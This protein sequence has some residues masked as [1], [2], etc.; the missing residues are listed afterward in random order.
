MPAI[1]KASCIVTD[2]HSC[3]LTEINL[4]TTTRDQ[5]LQ[6]EFSS[7]SLTQSIPN[8]PIRARSNGEAFGPTQIELFSLKKICF[9]VV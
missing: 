8:L 1:S 6:I 4:H 7:I 9:V 2:V 3:Q 5:Q